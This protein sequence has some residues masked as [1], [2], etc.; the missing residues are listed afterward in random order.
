MTIKCPT[1]WND[2]TVGE[3]QQLADLPQ[4][5]KPNRRML[6]IITILCQ[7]NALEL[8]KEPLEEIKQCL[9]FMNTEI[10]KARYSSFVHE[11]ITYEWIKSIDEI[12]L[13]EM[14]SIEQTI[15]Q[16][17]LNIAESFDL[18]MAVLLVEKGGKFDATKINEKRELYSEF[19]IDKV[20]GMLLFFLSGGRIHSQPIK[21]F[22]VISKAKKVEATGLMKRDEL[23]KRLTKKL[24]RT[25]LNGLLWL[26][27]SL[28]MILQSMK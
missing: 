9:S 11:G 10:S 27:V 12:T 25:V 7:V 18:I 4:D 16:E 8:D 14:I 19:P 23:M 1:I 5:A 21:K 20:H 3:F 22:L 13:G 28:K 2:V 15:E 17:E 24:V 26:T 6:D